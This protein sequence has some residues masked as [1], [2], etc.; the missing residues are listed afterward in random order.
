M[1]PQIR[2]IEGV[3]RESA[4]LHPT[5]RGETPGRH[6]VQSIRLSSSGKEYQRGGDRSIAIGHGCQTPLARSLKRLNYEPEGDGPMQSS[7]AEGGGAEALAD[8]CGWRVVVLLGSQLG[9]QGHCLLLF[10][11]YIIDSISG[12]KDRMHAPKLPWSVICVRDLEQEHT[13]QFFGTKWYSLRP[14]NTISSC[15]YFPSMRIKEDGTRS[16]IAYPHASHSVR[17]KATIPAAPR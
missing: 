9:Q 5:C 16:V 14:G 2:V 4:R 7:E 17:Q 15:L 13:A 1:E 3:E 10:R 6:R 12:P 8:C 11:F